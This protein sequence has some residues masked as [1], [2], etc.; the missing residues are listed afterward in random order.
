MVDFKKDIVKNRILPNRY[1]NKRILL[2]TI[3]DSNLM[4][5]KILLPID[6]QHNVL[7]C[8][9]LYYTVEWVDFL[10]FLFSQCGL[11]GCQRTLNYSL[12]SKI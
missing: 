6:I 2:F 11:Y 3:S 1:V 4:R 10:L 5:I 8:N 9:V 7:H 12:I